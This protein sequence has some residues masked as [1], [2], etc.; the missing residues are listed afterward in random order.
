[1]DQFGFVG[2]MGWNIGLKSCLTFR[3]VKHHQETILSIG[4]HKIVGGSLLVICLSA[5]NIL[6]RQ[7]NIYQIEQSKKVVFL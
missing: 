5:V 7:K 1:M 3:W 4:I 6:Q 2:M